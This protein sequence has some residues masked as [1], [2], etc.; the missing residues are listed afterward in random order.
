[1]VRARASADAFPDFH[2]IARIDAHGIVASAVP[3]RAHLQSIGRNVR[4]EPEAREAFDRAKA[5]KLTRLSKPHPLVHEDKGLTVFVPLADPSQ[6]FVSA[7]FRLE[8]LVAGLLP[9]GRSHELAVSIDGPNPASGLVEE[10]SLELFG[11]T[12]RLLV[13]PS[14]ARLAHARRGPNLLLGFGLVLAFLTGA[15]TFEISRNRKRLREQEGHRRV[16]LSSVQDHLLRVSPELSVLAYHASD[17]GPRLPEPRQAGTWMPERL[18]A[19]VRETLA[20][21]QA[22]DVEVEVDDRHFEARVSP[23]PDGSAVLR[24]RDVTDHRE[25]ENERLLLSRLVDSSVHLACVLGPNDE[26]EYLNPTG[27][28][29]LGLTQIPRRLD[30]FIDLGDEAVSHPKEW[31]GTWSGRVMARDA[32]L[33][34]FPIHLTTFSITTERGL[35]LGLV[36]VDLRQTVELESQLRQAHKM[37]SIGAIAAG[38]AHDFNNAV[39]V[40]RTGIDLLAEAENLPPDCAEDLDLLRSAAVSAGQ[41]AHQI[42]AVARP[43]GAGTNQVAIEVDVALAASARMITKAIRDDIELQWSLGARR[44]EILGDAGS[45]QQVVL[46]LVI[47]ARDAIPGTGRITIRTGYDDPRGRLEL[48]VEDTG[49]GIP[50]ALRERIFDPFFTTKDTGRGTGLGLAMVQ[51]TIVAWGG[52]VKAG[53]SASGGTVIT[54][55]VPAR[56]KSLAANEDAPVTTPSMVAAARVLL[57]DDDPTLRTVL[58]RALQRAGY[59]VKTAS[60]GLEALNLI[61]DET[62]ILV[63]DLIMPRMGGLELARRVRRAFPRVRVLLLSGHPEVTDRLEAGGAEWVSKPLDAR[64]IVA[65]IQDTLDRRAS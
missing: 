63:T 28:A 36:A 25:L 24:L 42:L 48:E 37:E 19:C 45:L 46:N 14:E 51:Q 57:V 17:R 16:L 65:R 11:Q 53:A 31:R 4:A 6:G 43:S 26:V 33:R 1:V 21:G 15:L 13:A 47:N 49:S 34:E 3:V 54:I 22:R 35:R 60:D 29:M 64:T 55:E 32:S 2:R 62:D 18:K 59:L 8:A 10:R 23:D 20:S 52:Q 40:F 56:R 12:L 9:G 41:V 50:E 27:L 44:V 39:T 58:E 61:E 38:V 7:S 30:G 5:S